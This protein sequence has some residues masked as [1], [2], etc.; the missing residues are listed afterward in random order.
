MLI[1]ESI[2]IKNKIKNIKLSNVIGKYITT[3]NNINI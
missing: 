3:C 2:L 1:S